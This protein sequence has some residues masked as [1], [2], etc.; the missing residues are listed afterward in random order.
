MGF[1]GLDNYGE[2][3]HA[4]NLADSVVSAVCKEL[5]EGVKLRSN[6]YNTP[7]PINV[8]LFAEAFLLSSTAWLSYECV[9]NTLKKA[10]K[11]LEE[12]REEWKD[13]SPDLLKAIER[14]IVNLKAYLAKA[15]N[16][17]KERYI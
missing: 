17:M 11:V 10:L 14:M 7:G 4:A 3:D 8:A 15:P 13:S 16:W 9:Y 2:S 12:E 5:K 6:E 1:M